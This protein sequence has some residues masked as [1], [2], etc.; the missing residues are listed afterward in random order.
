MAGW[1][2]DIPA[3]LDRLPWS[4]WHWRVALALGIAWVLDGLEVTL[5]GSVG[6]VLERPDTLGLSASQVGWTGSLYILGAVIGALVFGRMA[7]RLGRK[8][9]FLATLFVYM[10]ATLLTAFSPNFAFFALCRF[11]T[12]LGIGGEYAAINS[13]IDELIPARVRGRV[14]LAI[15]GSFWLG[16][17]LGAGLSLVVL[18]PRVLGP[19]WGW[20]ACFALGAVLAVAIVLIRRHVPES[21]RWL[22]THG[23]RAEAERVIAGIEAEVAARHGPLPPADPGA[24][25]AYAGRPVPTVREIVGLLVRRYRSRSVVTLM[26]MVAQAFFYNAIFFTYALV[27]TRFYGVAEERVALYIFPFA[28]GNALGPLILGP[29]FDRV[30]RRKMIALTYVLSGIGLAATGWAFMEGWLDARAQALCWSAVFFL[31]SAAASSA[32]L[33]ASEVFPLEM[34]ALAISVFYAVGTGTG[35]F[36]APVL[37]G[38]LI[39]TGSRGAVAVG[40]AIG[41]A[42]VIVAGLLALRFGVD[43]ERRPLEHIA[44]PL[45]SDADIMS[46]HNKDR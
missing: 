42:L 11:L 23:H 4:A 8:R 35:G 14:N 19:V 31:A 34:R 40:Y 38:M 28:I 45:G 30:G 12:G 29:L 9:L 15:N 7:D 24:H 6:A 39:E 20:R 44:P 25:V 36:I 46:I 27:L 17:A 41:A 21:P 16:A 1:Q 5:V 22:A 37:F 2:S 26:L 13:A 33:T 18:D 3:R 43:A 10:T 32:Y